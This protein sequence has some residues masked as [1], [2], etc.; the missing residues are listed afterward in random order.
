MLLTFPLCHGC[1]VTRQE[2][3]IDLK[4]C[5]L[6]PTWFRQIKVIL[7]FYNSNSQGMYSLAPLHQIPL[8]SFLSWGRE[9]RGVE[10]RA[11]ERRRGGGRGSP[12]RVFDVSEALCQTSLSLGPPGKPGDTVSGRKYFIG[13]GRLTSFRWPFRFLLPAPSSSGIFPPPP[14]YG[15]LE[16]GLQP[17]HLE[18]ISW[19]Y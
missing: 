4:T 1:T 16:T 2:V 12:S 13:S 14:G 15:C 11:R 17:S 5:K 9:N 7:I 6:Q 19:E 3:S 8:P 10:E 18:Y